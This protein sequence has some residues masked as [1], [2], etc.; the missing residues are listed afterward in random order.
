[1]QTS[2]VSFV[3]KSAASM[4]SGK[5]TVPAAVGSMFSVIFAEG[6]YQFSVSWLRQGF[7]YQSANKKGGGTA[8]SVTSKKGDAP[9]QQKSSRS[10]ESPEDV[11]VSFFI[12]AISN[13]NSI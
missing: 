3:R 5:R 6:S 9:A 4:L 11:E 13:V 12:F 1:M 8:K 7:C 10:T 2:E